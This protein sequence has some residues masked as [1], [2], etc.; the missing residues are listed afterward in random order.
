[1]TDGHIH[2]VSRSRAHTRTQVK[3]REFTHRCHAADSK[4]VR[5]IP[6]PQERLVS[7]GWVGRADCT[8]TRIRTHTRKIRCYPQGG[9]AGSWGRQHTL[10][11]HSSVMMGR[12]MR[13]SGSAELGGGG[14]GRQHI[15]EKGRQA[16]RQAKNIQR[17]GRTLS[18][19]V[20]CIHTHAVNKQVLT[21][22]RPS[23]QPVGV[24]NLTA[25]FLSRHTS[26]KNNR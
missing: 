22:I 25:T 20:V 11:T 10:H 26:R 15:H 21:R 7:R 16:S 12:C 14:G 24:E 1:M 3:T 6:S 13:H 9:K 8:R 19:V 18:L 2:A 17:H 5:L 23:P 4:K